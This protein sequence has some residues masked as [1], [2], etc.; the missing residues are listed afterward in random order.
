[1]GDTLSDNSNNKRIECKWRYTTK[2]YAKVEEV[3]DED[4]IFNNYDVYHQQ[5]D[6]IYCICSM[7]SFVNFDLDI[8]LFLQK[9]VLWKRVI[10]I[11]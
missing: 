9:T 7:V 6:S 5:R 2:K 10:Y 4:I 3:I 11:D 1:M 8:T